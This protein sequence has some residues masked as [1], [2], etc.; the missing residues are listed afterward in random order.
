[1]TVGF[2]A[3]ASGFYADQPDGFVVYEAAEESDGVGA[4]T[5]TCDGV[6]GEASDLGE[7]LGARFFSDDVLEVADE[8]RVRVRSDGAADEVVG[9]LDVGD[10]VSDC[11]VD[12]VFEGAAT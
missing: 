4:T 10:P 12:G 3:V 9:G 1:M 5:Y 2:D 8:H 11:F 7:A 6:V